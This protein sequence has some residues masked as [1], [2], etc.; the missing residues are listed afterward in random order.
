VGTFLQQ[1]FQ[2]QSTRSLSELLILDIISKLGPAPLS[3]IHEALR[4]VTQGSQT[5]FFVGQPLK[6][7][8][9]RYRDLKQIQVTRQSP[10][11]TY[12]L[13]ASAR[14]QVQQFENQLDQLFPHL[15]DI[16]PR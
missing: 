13:T 9:E 8:L 5:L 3:D 7:V 4:N 15:R 2:S 11:P 16:Q 12:E 6:K 14:A 10:E 1:R